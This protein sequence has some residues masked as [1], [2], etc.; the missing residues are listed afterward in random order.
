MTWFQTAMATEAP[1][2]SRR[3]YKQMHRRVK[4]QREDN[5][6]VDV[7]HVAAIGDVSAF[8]EVVRNQTRDVVIQGL[9]A[10]RQLK[11]IAI[12]I[13]GTRA[14][15]LGSVAMEQ[16]W[17]QDYLRA[18]NK[19]ASWARRSWR[20]Y[21]AVQSWKSDVVAKLRRGHKRCHAG[22]EHGEKVM[23]HAMRELLHRFTC[24]PR[25]PL[26]AL[27]GHAQPAEPDDVGVNVGMRE[28]LEAFSF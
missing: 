22:G 12:R 13:W 25:K 2:N 9:K 7:Q 6:K 20:Q 5:Q 27:Y 16:N 1:A 24:K 28:F 10:S 8:K 3:T 18:V 15:S 21:H 4:L 26:A 19:S 17:L 23:D 14:V 11:A